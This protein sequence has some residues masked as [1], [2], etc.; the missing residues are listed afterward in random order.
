MTSQIIGNTILANLDSTETMDKLQNATPMTTPSTIPIHLTS[1]AKTTTGALQNLTQTHAP[2]YPLMGG[3]K[4]RQ[5]I[6]YLRLTM[7]LCISSGLLRAFG[8]RHGPPAFGWLSITIS[9]AIIWDRGFSSTMWHTPTIKGTLN[10][11]T[12]VIG[13][14]RI[15]G[16]SPG[17]ETY[18]KKCFE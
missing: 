8:L 17:S 4:K 15:S 10:T 2:L 16:I 18:G 5:C 3:L 11:S 6:L 1:I 12:S 7:C 14:W 9:I 13:G